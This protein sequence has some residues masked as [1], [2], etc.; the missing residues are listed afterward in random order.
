VPTIVFHGDQDRTVNPRNGD[1][2][3]LSSSRHPAG[4]RRRGGG[5]A[6][7][8]GEGGRHVA[9][10]T[11]GEPGMH[12][13]RQVVAQAR[14]TTTAALQATATVQQ[15]QTPG[16]RAYRRT[17]HADAGGQALLEQWVG[18]IAPLSEASRTQ[19]GWPA[20]ASISGHF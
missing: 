9:G 14:S 7:H 10:S 6:L 16:G 17:M 8:G 20:K 18:R 5:S 11:S 3:P 15:G 1:H 12:A 19:R 2:P 13:D 4:L